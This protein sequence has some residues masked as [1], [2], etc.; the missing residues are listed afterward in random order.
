MIIDKILEATPKRLP[1][2][3]WHGTKWMAHIAKD[4]FTMKVDAFG[5]SKFIEGIRFTTDPRKLKNY[6]VYPFWME[7][8]TV[9][10][11]A[12]DFEHR[13]EDGYMFLEED[14]YAYVK[15]NTL[16][17]R[18]KIKAIYVHEKVAR[19]V[20]KGWYKPLEEKAEQYNIAI[21]YGET[22]LWK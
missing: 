8:S 6:E 20:R 9:G 4:D 15:G 19:D 1:K 12:S 10:L 18:G 21:V 17:L 7:V 14:E 16:P 2:I 5:N 3:L 13:S 22:W 11:R